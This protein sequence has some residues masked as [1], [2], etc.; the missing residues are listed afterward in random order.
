MTITTLEKIKL[1]NIKKLPIVILPLE[2]YEKMRED[3]DVLR[4]L[5]L[6][7]DIKKARAEVKRGRMISFSEAKKRLKLR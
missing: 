6:S 3:L 5:K 4:S 7:K 1:R 2:N